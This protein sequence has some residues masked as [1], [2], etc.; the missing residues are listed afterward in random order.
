MIDRAQGEAR[1]DQDREK[2]EEPTPAAPT[3]FHDLGE[4]KGVGAKEIHTA[5]RARAGPKEGNGG[6]V[7]DD[8]SGLLGGT[9]LV[10]ACL[11]KTLPLPEAWIHRRQLR[12]A[13]WALGFCSDLCG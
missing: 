2:H 10:P 11:V 13:G 7:P 12:G 1:D 8:S 6:N 9:C 5:P 4:G 3:R